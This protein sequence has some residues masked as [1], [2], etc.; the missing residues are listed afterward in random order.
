MEATIH[1]EIWRQLIPSV[2]HLA[3]NIYEASTM[4]Q[5]LFKLST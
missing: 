2:I 1:S 4:Y 3:K 5:A